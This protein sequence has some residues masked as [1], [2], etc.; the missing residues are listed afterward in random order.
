MISSIRGR[1]ASR[2]SYV[3]ISSGVELRIIFVIVR[4]A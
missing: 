3:Y 4:I 1:N 2:H